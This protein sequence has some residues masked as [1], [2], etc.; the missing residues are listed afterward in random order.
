MGYR[1]EDDRSRTYGTYGEEGRDRER[2]AFDRDEEPSR[3]GMTGWQ[4][5]RD[6]EGIGGDAGA[7]RD[8]G[9]QSYLTHDDRFRFERIGGYGTGYGPGYAGGYGGYRQPA[10]WDSFPGGRREYGPNSH[11]AHA[12]RAEEEDRGPFWGKGPKGYRRSD[13]RI[14]E[15]VCDAVAHQGYIDAS[16]VEVRVENAVVVL[17]GTVAQRGD[18]RGLEHIAE[19][20]HGVHDV[21]NEIRVRREEPGAAWQ[22]R[23]RMQQQQQLGGHDGNRNAGPSR[24]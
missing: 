16:D 13:E 24:S 1:R 22:E 2:R 7:E 9:R 6:R 8:M 21:R 4:G 11:E 17:T 23:Q 20:V 12:W 15:D 10:G 19:R 3:A 5:D 18:K 14:R